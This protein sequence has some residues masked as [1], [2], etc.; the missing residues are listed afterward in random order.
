LQI[1]R[2]S[3]AT[4]IGCV[5]GPETVIC[6]WR[7]VNECGDEI[8]R[9]RLSQDPLL[10]RSEGAEG[11]IGYHGRVAHPAARSQQS[12]PGARLKRLWRI[13]ATLSN[14]SRPVANGNEV[15]LSVWYA[16]Y[17]R[18]GTAPIGISSEALPASTDAEVHNCEWIHDN[19]LLTNEIYEC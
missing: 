15:A 14:N 4:K 1:A 7:R 3:D 5:C 11:A 19:F 2:D 12:D 8:R 17:G 13:W 16:G 10:R 18:N 6:L 9:R